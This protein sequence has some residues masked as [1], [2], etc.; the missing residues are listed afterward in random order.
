L[1]DRNEAIEPEHVDQRAAIAGIDGPG[2]MDLGRAELRQ[3]GGCQGAATRVALQIET[4]HAGGA[5]QLDLG[6]GRAARRAGGI[7]VERK[8]RMQLERDGAARDAAD[9]IRDR[10]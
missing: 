1:T 4:E 7:P 2:Q 10:A 8:R 9:S 3:I 5:L 6:R